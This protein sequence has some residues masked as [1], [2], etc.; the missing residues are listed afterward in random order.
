[1]AVRHAAPAPA[2]AVIELKPEMYRNMSLNLS[3]HELMSLSPG[4][5]ICW[6]LPD[7]L[8]IRVS[9]GHMSRGDQH[10]D[11]TWM[12]RAALHVDDPQKVLNDAAEP[13]FESTHYIYISLELGHLYHRI[14]WSNLDRPAT[15]RTQLEPHVTL[16]YLPIS[17]PKTLEQIHMALT[18]TLHL[19]LNSRGRPTSRPT[20]YSLNWNRMV[21][22]QY[23]LDPDD[24]R[25]IDPNIALDYYDDSH[26]D[27]V[28]DDDSQPPRPGYNGYVNSERTFE[29]PDRC[30]LAGGNNGTITT[31]TDLH[32]SLKELP[33]GEALVRIKHKW[34]ARVKKLMDVEHEVSSFDSSPYSHR[35]DLE[36][37]RDLPVAVKLS[38]NQYG[39]VDKTSELRSLLHYLVRR[40]ETLGL[41]GSTTAGI[42]PYIGRDGT[43]HA[44]LAWQPADLLRVDGAPDMAPLIGK[45]D[46]LLSPPANVI[47]QHWQKTGKWHHSTVTRYPPGDADHRGYPK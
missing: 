43:W 13:S 20:D 10:D 40:M 21:H 4:G 44:T 25:G 35:D 11:W 32:P 28:G 29:V 34:V 3:P 47:I 37:S 18:N 45:A 33:P 9:V 14:K 7:N 38:P 27:D 23:R 42:K 39:H 30:L 12:Q 26:S 6:V 15:F 1:M 41:L 19:W 5:T 16:A 24:L 22:R 17:Q 2:A 36:F 46:D 8:R 31:I